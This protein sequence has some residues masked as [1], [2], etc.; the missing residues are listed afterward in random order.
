MNLERRLKGHFDAV[1]GGVGEP[2]FDVERV[3]QRGRR[4][5]RV[6]MAAIGVNMMVVVLA[7]VVGFRALT[8]VN[9]DFAPAA[10]PSGHVASPT[11]GAPTPSAPATE[12][13]VA[14]TPSP[15]PSS[16]TERP[17]TA[18]V[19]VIDPRELGTTVFAYGAADNEGLRLIDSAGSDLTWPGRVALA[20]PDGSGGIVVQARSGDIVW[21]PLDRKAMPLDHI[22][23]PQRDRAAVALRDVE[24]DGSVVYSTHL[25]G[26]SEDSVANIFSVGLEGGTPELLGTEPTYESWFV[27]PVATSDGRLLAGCHLLCSLGHWP[28][29]PQNKPVH[30][31]GAEV[32]IEALDV[33]DHGQLVA[34][35]ESNEMSKSIPQLVVLEVGTWKERL[36]LPLPVD[37]TTRSAGAVISMSSDGERILVSLDSPRRATQPVPRKTFLVDDALGDNPVVRRVDYEGV[38]RWLDPA[39]ASR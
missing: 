19:E 1:G 39:A 31:E 32:A 37:K 10:P 5:R 20:I 3:M 17:S 4:R 21:E 11:A 16:A 13:E 7:A 35:V 25:P 38:V 24:S 34:L 12:S 18:S 6:Q 8:A 29:S 9:V 30:G 26:Y 28:D 23:D 27:G 22:K 2:D 15:F 36:R 14:A 33:A